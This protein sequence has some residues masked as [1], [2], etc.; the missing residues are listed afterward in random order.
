M[1]TLEPKLESLLMSKAFETLNAE[2]RLYVS[3]FLTEEKYNA[4]HLILKHTFIGTQEADNTLLPAAE[5]PAKLKT[6]FDAIRKP[7]IGF[8]LSIKQ[9]SIAASL[10]VAISLGVILFKA[11]KLDKTQ[12]IPEQ[13][14]VDLT[15]VQPELKERPIDLSEKPLEQK[16]ASNV[17][18]TQKLKAVKQVNHVENTDVVVMPEEFYGLHVQEPL[19]GLEI[20]VNDR[21]LGLHAS[22]NTN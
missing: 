22:S 11:D 5:I 10:L 17:K 3:D 15:N 2:E 12:F 20:D 21:L 18:T 4:Y 16:L 19:L 13:T 1:H 9:L 7:S 6:H 8:G 14:K